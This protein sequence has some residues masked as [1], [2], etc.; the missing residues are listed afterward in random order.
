VA[1]RDAG[2]VPGCFRG[3]LPPPTLEVAAWLLLSLLLVGIGMGLF[4]T[5]I[6][7]AMMSGIQDRHVGSAS[8]VLTTTQRGGNALGVAAL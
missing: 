8:G 4:M 3:V 2:H 6:L 5:P 1:N 7:N